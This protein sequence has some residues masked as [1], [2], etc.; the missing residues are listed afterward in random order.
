MKNINLRSLGKNNA[1]TSSS[2]LITENMENAG[3]KYPRQY[4][5]IGN[6]P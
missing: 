4:R 1:V 6:Y 2:Y 3:K 5:W